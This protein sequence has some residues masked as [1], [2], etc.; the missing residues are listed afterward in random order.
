VVKEKP[1]GKNTKDGLSAV[2]VVWVSAFL[3]MA[4]LLAPE[5]R[6]LLTGAGISNASMVFIWFFK[7]ANSTD[8]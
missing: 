3:T 2:L 7:K 4:F 6:E 8:G 1:M 5:Q